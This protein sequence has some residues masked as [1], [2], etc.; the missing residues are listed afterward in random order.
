[1]QTSLFNCLLGEIPIHSG[2]VS[3]VGRIS[4]ASQEPWIFSGSARQNIL[5]GQPFDEKRYWS[6]IKV[7]AL[8]YDIF[9]W[10][11]RDHTLV[12]EKG[13]VLSGKG[14]YNKVTSNANII[15]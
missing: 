8:E 4:Y 15:N 7:C 2:K 3:T 11:H 10:E 9:Q 1:L 12:G 5:F 13:V 6:V 14:T